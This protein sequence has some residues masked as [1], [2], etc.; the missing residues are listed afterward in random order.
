MPTTDMKP[1]SLTVVQVHIPT[2]ALICYWCDFGVF[3]HQSKEYES[4]KHIIHRAKQ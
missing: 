2:L 3:L 4:S 1:Y